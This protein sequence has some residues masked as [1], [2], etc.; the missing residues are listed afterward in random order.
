[1]TKNPSLNPADY[2]LVTNSEFKAWWDK[3]PK[4]PANR[5]RVTV[6]RVAGNPIVLL[7]TTRKPKAR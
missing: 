1:M 2:R 6:K 7:V 4:N 3:N 5:K